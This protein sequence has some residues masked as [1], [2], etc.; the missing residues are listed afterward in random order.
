MESDGGSAEHLSQPDRDIDALAKNADAVAHQHSANAFIHIARKCDS[1][2]RVI[3]LV[4]IFAQVA[5]KSRARL[6]FARRSMSRMWPRVLSGFSPSSVA[7]DIIIRRDFH[8]RRGA[9]RRPCRRRCRRLFGGRFTVHQTLHIASD[10]VAIDGRDSRRSRRSR[11][12]I[13]GA[14]V[15]PTTRRGC[16]SGMRRRFLDQCASAR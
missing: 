13:D 6:R 5:R 1:L 16:A 2:L 7:D 14:G 4:P 3:S 10:R 11:Y 9:L 15:I 12:C 8:T